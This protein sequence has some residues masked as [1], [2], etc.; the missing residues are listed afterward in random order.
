MILHRAEPRATGETLGSA[1]RPPRCLCAHILVALSMRVL[2]LAQD[3]IHCY[4]AV[5]I[6]L[7]SFKRDG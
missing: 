5:R 7:L 4:E 2:A 3:P 6:I 1:L